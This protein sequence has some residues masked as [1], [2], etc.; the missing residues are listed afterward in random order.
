[1]AGMNMHDIMIHL[2][3]EVLYRLRDEKGSFARNKETSRA[4]YYRGYRGIIQ[5]DSLEIILLK[6]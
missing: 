6:L 4:L 2:K 3:F 1:M 5:T